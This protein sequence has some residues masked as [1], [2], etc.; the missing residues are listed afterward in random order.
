MEYLHT[1]SKCHNHHQEQ[2]TCWSIAV[3]MVRSHCSR[4]R[5]RLHAVCRPFSMVRINGC[6][7]RPGGRLQSLGNPE[8]TVRSAL[9]WS[10]RA[11]DLATC[12]KSR[13]CLSHR[14]VKSCVWLMDHLS[15]SMLVTRWKCQMRRSLLKHHC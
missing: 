12:P 3:S 9:E 10:I 1:L 14:T 2:A 8:I 7:G 6:L 4:Y 11:S 13:R 15:T 5:A